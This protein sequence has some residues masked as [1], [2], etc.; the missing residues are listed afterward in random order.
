MQKVRILQNISTAKR[1]VSLKSA[2]GQSERG[3]VVQD[4]LTQLPIYVNLGRISS[5]KRPETVDKPNW[6]D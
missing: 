4:N 2:I 5:E 3:C 6:R 1:Q